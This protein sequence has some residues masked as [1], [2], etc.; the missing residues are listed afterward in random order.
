MHFV[1]GHRQVDSSVQSAYY[2]HSEIKAWDPQKNQSNRQQKALLNFSCSG[3]GTT[4]DWWRRRI[5][6]WR[7]RTERRSMGRPPTRLRESA[8]SEQRKTDRYGDHCG[9]PMSSR[10]VFPLKWWWWYTLMYSDYIGSS[11]VKVNKQLKT[12][13]NS[14]AAC[15]SELNFK[16]CSFSYFLKTL[17][18]GGWYRYWL[19]HSSITGRL[20]VLVRFHTV[21]VLL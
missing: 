5:F 15:T 2:Y 18:N 1:R 7:P 8:G 12:L 11:L 4:N 19:T 10:D 9:R 3:Q 13:H 6:K 21:S 20:L 14:K 16:F 17:R